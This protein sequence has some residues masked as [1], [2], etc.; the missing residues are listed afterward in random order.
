MKTFETTTL[1]GY[2]IAYEQ[3]PVRPPGRCPWEVGLEI[4]FTADTRSVVTID[5]QTGDSISNP[6]TV[7]LTLEPGVTVLTL[8]TST[9]RPPPVSTIL[10]P[11]PRNLCVMISE[12]TAS[13]LLG[14][15]AQVQR[16]C[17]LRDDRMAP[18]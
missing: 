16:E 6:R 5:W 10:P 7:G 15:I 18:T 17:D 3:T 14:L 12:G 11:L 8:P 9:P 2:A 1:F 13:A 4:R